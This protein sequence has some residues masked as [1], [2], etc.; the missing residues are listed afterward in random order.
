MSEYLHHD[1]VVAPLVAAGVSC[2]IGFDLH[3]LLGYIG[4]IVGICSGLL[5]I[6]WVA[7]QIH[8][9]MKNDE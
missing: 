3:S 9:A 8:R 6:A 5:S 2:V 1:H 4:Q 7:Y